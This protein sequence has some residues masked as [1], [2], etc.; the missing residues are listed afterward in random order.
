M[1]KTGEKAEIQV[2]QGGGGGAEQGGRHAMHDDHWYHAKPLLR[3]I[4]VPNGNPSLSCGPYLLFVFCFP[5][6]VVDDID[7]LRR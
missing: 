3:H 5:V 4:P 6:P 7:I 1:L 2:S